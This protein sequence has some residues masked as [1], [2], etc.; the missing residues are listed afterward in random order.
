MEERVRKVSRE[1]TSPPPKGRN[2]TLEKP[3][4]SPEIGE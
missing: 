2:Y 1:S 3:E 4:R